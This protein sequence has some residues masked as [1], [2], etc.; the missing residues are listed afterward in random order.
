MSAGKAGEFVT[1]MALCQVPFII[2]G[3]VIDSYGIFMVWIIVSII[4]S[5]GA[6]GMLMIKRLKNVNDPNNMEAETIK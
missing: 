3:G 4:C 2:M 1:L 5:I 6:F